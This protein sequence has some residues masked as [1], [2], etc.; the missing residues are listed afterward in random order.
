MLHPGRPR[1][2]GRGRVPRTTRPVR[3]RRARVRAHRARDEVGAEVVD[4]VHR[5][6]HAPGAARRRPG[7]PLRDVRS[8]GRDGSHPRHL[9]GRPRPRALHEAHVLRAEISKPR[10][11]PVRMSAPARDGTRAL[12][13]I[14]SRALSSGRRELR[15]MDPP[16]SSA[17]SRIVSRA[18]CSL[19]IKPRSSLSL[20][21]MAASSTRGAVASRDEDR[22][23][24]SVPNRRIARSEVVKV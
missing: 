3:G 17:M 20:A 5:G 13:R 8:P 24:D 2:S 4:D 9:R 23:V 1:P 16:F 10:A 6:A 15:Q 12:A 19:A 14:G 22:R 7:P 11:D 18:A 21:C